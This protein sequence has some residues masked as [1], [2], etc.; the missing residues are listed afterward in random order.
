MR[1]DCTIHIQQDS[2]WVA[3]TRRH[4]RAGKLVAL[5]GFQEDLHEPPFQGLLKE[6]DFHHIAVPVESAQG[7]ILFLIPIEG[8]NNKNP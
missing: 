7:K 8:S 5:R 3:K 4:L 6:L 1:A 2:K